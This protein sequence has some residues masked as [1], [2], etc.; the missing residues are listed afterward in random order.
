M[1]TTTVLHLPEQAHL[2]AELAPLAQA[3]RAEA[4]AG[5]RQIRARED[6]RLKAWLRNHLAEATGGDVVTTLTAVT[7]AVVRM[8]VRR[9]MRRAGAPEGWA[10]EVGAF[11]VGGYGRGEMNPHSDLDLLLIARGAPPPW[12]AAAWREL[13]TLCWDAK[14]QL[15]GSL[16]ALPELEQ[17]LRGDFVTATALI[18]QRPVLAD[19]GLAAEVAAML[20]AFRQRDGREF[21]RYKMGELD[22]R[23]DQAGFSLFLMEPNLK[24]NPGGLRDVQLLRN[25]AFV[26]FGVRSLFA[27]DQ[28]EAITRDD[29]AG[30]ARAGDHLLRLR[31]LLHFHHGRKQDVLQ[32]ADQVR[33]A[34]DL[35]YGDVSRLRAVEHFMRDHYRQVQHVH[36]VLELAISR[37]R[38]QGVMS[39]RVALLRSRIDLPGGFT[40]LGGRIYAASDAAWDGP[41]W[42]LRLF[43]A[44]RAGQAQGHRLAL[45]LQRTLRGR[46][47]LVTPEQ[48]ADPRLGRLFLAM[49]GDLGRVGDL[50]ADL[51]DAGILG[52][53]LPEFGNLSCLMQFDSYHQYTVDRHTLLAMRYL[54]EVAL[55]RREG[56]PGMR[57]AFARTGRR[58]ILALGLLLHD[59]GKYMGRGHVARGALMVA[60]VARRLGLDE[61]EQDLL[62]FLV[63]RHVS[64]SDASRMRDFREPS[65][66]AQFAA[67]M[68]DEAR[69]DALYCLTYCDAK[70]V[71]DGVLTGWQEAILGELYEAVRDHLRTGGGQPAATHAVRLREALEE[72]GVPAAE[73]AA[74]LARFPGTY[75]HQ[76]PVAEVAAHYRV[77]SQ[78]LRE[79]VG[80]AIVRQ[81]RHIAFTAAVPDRHGL[82]ADVAATLS[83]H[84]LDIFA[85]R[86]WIT[87]DGLVIYQ[88]RLA[89]VASVDPDDAQVWDRLHQDLVKVADGRL[90]TR[91]LLERRRQQLLGSRPADSGFDDPAVKIENATSDSATILDVHAK[92]QV[93]LLSLL[94]RTISDAGCDIGTTCITTMGDAAVDVF[95]VSRGGT[96]LD[97][98]AAA[99]LRTRLIAALQLPA[100]SAQP[101]RA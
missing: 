4:I 90:D 41:D 37:L 24:A 68:G 81:D 40:A 38:S 50:L 69:L 52:A 96:K 35:G 74:F 25:L 15:G 23:R 36:Q 27:L 26:R 80:L 10:A 16:R 100:A 9:A 56:L 61:A 78:A 49:L 71:G 93:G 7:D 22:Q 92:D 58:E 43:T 67:R 47:H 85:A 14:F 79:R 59:M 89:P 29:L 39:E 8:L 51:H 72:A 94:C 62:H 76:V 21:L 98:A 66:L 88:M 83:G 20:D 44:C 12:A 87:A 48:R 54:D 82:L 77:V 17:L 84:G 63:D 45:E 73:A 91:R 28:L 55:G 31:S 53:W 86:S 60:Q 99:D 2:D 33:I 101:G 65:F 18:E 42:L 32:L 34:N 46:A 57:A 95:Y 70:A 1:L 6:L 3:P 75:I 97:D 13:E 19:P 11:A 5:V 64:L 30:V